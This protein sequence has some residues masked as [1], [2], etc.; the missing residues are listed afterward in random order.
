MSLR[1]LLGGKMKRSVQTTPTIIFVVHH[2][3]NVA[4]NVS[5]GEEYSSVERRL[6]N[7][8]ELGAFMGGVSP[9]NSQPKIPLAGGPLKKVGNPLYGNDFGIFLR[10]YL[11]L[12]LPQLSTYTS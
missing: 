2:M 12:Q 5:S 10:P 8:K 3:F 1:S 9:L 4:S 7:Y 6:P 11:H